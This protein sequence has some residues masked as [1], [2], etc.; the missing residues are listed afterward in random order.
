MGVVWQF[1]MMPQNSINST[2]SILG[3]MILTRTIKNESTWGHIL[4][5][6]YTDH[7]VVREHIIILW[8]VDI[9]KNTIK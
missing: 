9:K 2:P 1:D 8:R 5:Y 7:S 3:M 6:T 4:S